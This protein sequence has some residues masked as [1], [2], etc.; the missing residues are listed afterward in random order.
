MVKKK[1]CNYIYILFIYIDVGLNMLYKAT[2]YMMY[3]YSNYYLYNCIYI[4]NISELI[5]HLL[6]NVYYFYYFIT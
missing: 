3:I 4:V 1:V 6:Y 2:I 5:L